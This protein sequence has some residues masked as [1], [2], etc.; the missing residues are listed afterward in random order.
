M[1]KAIHGR[2]ACDF[3]A[4]ETAQTPSAKD[5]LRVCKA[6]ERPSPDTSS[7]VSRTVRK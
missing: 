5:G 7:L 3:V 4:L 1:H 2:V 6:R